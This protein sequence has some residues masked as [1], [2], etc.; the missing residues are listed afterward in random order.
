[1]KPLLPE[2]H[3]EGKT[4]SDEIKKYISRKTEAIQNQFKK[5][6]VTLIEDEAD[7]Q[8]YTSKKVT[9]KAPKKSTVQETMNCEKNS[10]ADIAIECLQNKLFMHFVN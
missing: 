10:I 2:N 3:F 4:D 5:A 1:L 7:L 8:R 9:K 6:N